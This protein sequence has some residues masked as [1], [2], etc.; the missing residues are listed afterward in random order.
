MAGTATQ[1][2]AQKDA[3][4][5]KDA[6]A[7]ALAQAAAQAAQAQ[8]V[9]PVT[10]VTPE[11][12]ETPKERRA[13]LAREQA[14]KAAKEARYTPSPGCEWVEVEGLGQVSVCES[15]TGFYYVVFQGRG[16]EHAIPLIA[17][18]KLQEAGQI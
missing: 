10:P 5:K 18:E 6:E 15:S 17:V 3:Q 12:E 9:T 1:T 4:A 14:A 11:G 2:Q 16:R 7:Q 8:P 13:R